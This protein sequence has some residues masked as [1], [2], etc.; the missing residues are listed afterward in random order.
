MSVNPA[1]K[2][3]T[4]TTAKNGVIHA[5]NLTN[6]DRKYINHIE[7]LTNWEAFQAQASSG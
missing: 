5:L 1:F 6:I 3:E 2:I 4:L 7:C